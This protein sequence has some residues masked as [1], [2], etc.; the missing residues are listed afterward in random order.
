MGCNDCFPKKALLD[1]NHT[2]HLHIVY[3]YFLAIMAELSSCEEGHIALKVSNIYNLDLY[4]KKYQ[5]LD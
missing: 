3:G 2:Y 1:Y 4:Q 5:P